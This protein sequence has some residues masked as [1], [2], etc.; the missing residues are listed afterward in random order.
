MKEVSHR[1]TQILDTKRERANRGW[2]PALAMIGTLSVI[3]I[4][5]MPYAPEL[6]SFQNKTQPVFSA[7]SDVTP[8]PIKA[9]P[10]VFKEPR[11]RTTRRPTDSASLNARAKSNAN[12][13]P[14]KATMHKKDRTPKLMMAKASERVIPANMFLVWHSSQFDESSVWTLTVWRFGSASG[15]Q[16]MVQETIVM[17][18][19]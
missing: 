6:I 13:V 10:V 4:G 16:Q 9:I 18:S 8:L 11:S 12:V 14:A 2:R 5:A 7:A 15:G 1:I 19:L 3:T 17:N